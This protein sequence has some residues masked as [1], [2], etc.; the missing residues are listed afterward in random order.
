MRE[1]EMTGKSTYYSVHIY[2]AFKLN[3]TSERFSTR[4]YTH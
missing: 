2:I 1:S 4:L 3:N